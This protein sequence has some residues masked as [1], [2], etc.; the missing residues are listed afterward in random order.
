MFL[1]AKHALPPML[2][3]GRGSIINLGSISAYTGQE[4][5]GQSQ[6][7]YNVTKAAAVQLAVS[8]G[9]RYG[10]EGVRVNAVCPGVTA[11][12]ML[13]A[14]APGASDAEYAELWDSFARGSTPLNRA[15][16]P[17]EV[18]AAIAFLASDDGSFVT[19][20]SLIVDGGFLGR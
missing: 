6:W 17:E 18:A 3:K 14:S 13:R 11:T 10:P 15:A 16:K 12:G 8:L 20:T 5:D 2:A 4:V 1:C 19:A 7:L 9:T